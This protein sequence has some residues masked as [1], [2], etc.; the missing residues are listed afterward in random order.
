[1]GTEGGARVD[2]RVP[3]K[4]LGDGAEDGEGGGGRFMRVTSLRSA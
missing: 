2:I 4:D 1:M 3:W